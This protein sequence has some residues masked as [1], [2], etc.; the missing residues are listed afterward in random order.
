MK[1]LYLAASFATMLIASPVLADSNDN[2]STVEQI[3]SSTDALITQQGNSNKNDSTVKQGHLWTPSYNSHATVTQGGNNNH[4]NLSEIEQINYNNTATV[5]QGG[6]WNQNQ[7]KVEQNGTS[8]VYGNSATVTQDGYDND[9]TSK[10]GQFGYN[11][12]A[13]VTQ[14]GSYNTNWSKVTQGGT[15]LTA[16]VSQH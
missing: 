15:S 5:T 6:D 13:S 16:T 12:A 14:G 1:K 8:A 7:S 4:S 9:N 11:N 2:T 10:I 3:G